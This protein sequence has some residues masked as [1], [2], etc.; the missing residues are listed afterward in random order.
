MS[1]VVCTFELD[2]KETSRLQCSGFGAVVAFS[3]HEQGRGNP[4]W[5]AVENYGPIPHGTYYIVDRQSGG[6]MGPLRDAVSRH[7]YGSSDRTTWFTLWNPRTGDSTVVNGVTRGN[8]RLHPRGAQGRSQG[9]IVVD[10]PSDFD[11][12]ERYLRARKPVIPVPGTSLKAYGKV[13]VR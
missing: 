1:S 4:D 3:G 5:T 11:R 10:N 7:I 2:R 9:C 13:I 8:F 12:L 6:R